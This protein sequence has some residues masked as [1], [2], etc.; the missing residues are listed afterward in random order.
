VLRALKS[1]LRKIESF[2][3][4]TPVRW[5]PFADEVGQENLQAMTGRVLNAGAGDRSLQPFVKGTVVNQDIAEGLHNRDIHIYSPLHSIP[6]EDEH[7]DY[8]FCNAVLE[9]VI[10]PDEVVA[11]FVRVLKPGGTLYLCVPFLQP[12]HLDP[13]DFQRYTKDGLRHLVEK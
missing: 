10:N 4:R 8:I 11:E 13:T 5:P 12:E 9:H 1:V 2:N 6:V 3:K 7:F